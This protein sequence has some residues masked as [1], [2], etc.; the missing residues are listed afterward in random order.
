M[1]QAQTFILGGYETTAVALAYCLYCLA[2]H[3]GAQGRLVQE[4]DAFGRGRDVAARDMD[5]VGLMGAGAGRAGEWLEGVMASGG[6]WRW[7]LWGRA[8]LSRC[9]APAGRCRSLSAIC[10]PLTGRAVPRRPARACSCRSQTRASRRRYACTP[11]HVAP[12][13]QAHAGAPRR[14]L[15]TQLYI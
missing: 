14:A 9:P 4:V 7:G 1:A 2:L 13:Q 10:S 8:V 6:D 5:Q 12:H 15:C 11:Q 3:P